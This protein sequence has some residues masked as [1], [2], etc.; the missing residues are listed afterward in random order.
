MALGR[1]MTER[2][3]KSESGEPISQICEEFTSS[4]D[5]ALKGA[6]EPPRIEH[7]L[8]RVSDGD[9]PELQRELNEIQQT[10]CKSALAHASGWSAG[11]TNTPTRSVSEV[12]RS[13]TV[14]QN[15]VTP[16]PEGL[17]TVDSVPKD[18][19]DSP[20]YDPSATLDHITKDPS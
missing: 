4:W 10:F 14:D 13:A 6:G 16:S 9:R 7:F 19:N 20:A 8:T 17:A 3:Q 12:W 18:K 2:L 15:A 5:T 11:S 1:I